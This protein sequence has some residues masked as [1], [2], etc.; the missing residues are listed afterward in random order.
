M[1][2]KATKRG[3][4]GFAFSLATS[5]QAVS[6]LITS[7]L[8]ASSFT[9][10][11]AKAEDSILDQKG[12][13]KVVR[14][15]PH[16]SNERLVFSDEKWLELRK[17]LRL[18]DLKQV[19]DGFT[20]RF[21]KIPIVGAFEVFTVAK[22]GDKISLEREIW[23]YR[24]NRKDS[25]DPRVTAQLFPGSQLQSITD[26][27]TKTD[28]WN[29]PLTY[30]ESG[31]N[32]GCFYFIECIAPEHPYKITSGENATPYE[33]LYK[34]LSE[35]A[36]RPIDTKSFIPPEQVKMNP[37]LAELFSPDNKIRALLN[38]KDSKNSINKCFLQLTKTTDK[39]SFEQFTLEEEGG[40][41]KLQRRTINI[42]PDQN[43]LPEPKVINRKIKAAGFAKAITWL[44]S[45]N[46]W[47]APSAPTDTKEDAHVTYMIG[48]RTEKHPFHTIMRTD[49]E[50][51]EPLFKILSKLAR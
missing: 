38:I 2:M 20:L 49:D 28:F 17:I 7:F 8:A 4:T 16:K 39:G 48:S 34:I 14:K 6:L 12:M 36:N 24:G 44:E 23:K 21:A 3:R 29:L 45:N 47:K 30:A 18:Q 15:P 35:L 19:N 9:C 50:S 5:F 10:L 40:K 46:F 32:D 25:G 43:E 11:P 1:S 51:Y 37:R 22:I 42:K 26:W 33:D 13:F 31:Y 41:I 27:Q